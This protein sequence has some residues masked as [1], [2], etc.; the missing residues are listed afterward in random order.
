M[1]DR[2]DPNR[3]FNLVMAQSRE[4]GPTEVFAYIDFSEAVWLWQMAK[5]K[6]VSPSALVSEIIREAAFGRRP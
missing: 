5:I 4:I 1:L 6:G 3:E 2:A